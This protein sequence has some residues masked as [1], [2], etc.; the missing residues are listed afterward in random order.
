[1]NPKHITVTLLGPSGTMQVKIRPEDYGADIR[2]TYVP[3]G[4]G[5][6]WRCIFKNIGHLKYALDE[7]KN[8]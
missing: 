8:A 4:M 1:M 6:V 3:P 7:V 2:M 5:R